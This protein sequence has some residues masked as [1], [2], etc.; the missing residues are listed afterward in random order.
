MP[1]VTHHTTRAH[2]A[3]EPRPTGVRLPWALVIAGLGLV[4]LAG[5]LLHP[6]CRPDVPGLAE[7]ASGV[8]HE[9]RDGRW[10]H[11]EPWIRSVLSR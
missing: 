2:P 4:A 10:I 5:V 9:Q 11:C 6:A 1:P 8:R 7:S 3:Y